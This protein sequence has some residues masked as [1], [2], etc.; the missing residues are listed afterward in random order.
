LGRILQVFGRIVRASGADSGACHRRVAALGHR[1]FNGGPRDSY[2]ARMP[3]N[4]AERQLARFATTRWSLIRAAAGPPADPEARGALAG[5]CEAY[6]Y[7]LYAFIRRRGYSS[8]DAQDLTQEFFARVLEKGFIKS[9]DADRGRFRSFLLTACRHFLANE[10]ERAGAKKRGAGRVASLELGSGEERYRREP[11]HELTPER[12]YERNW[13]LA[14][15]ER[16]LGRLRSEYDAAGKARLFDSLKPVLTG[17]DD[18]ASYRRLADALGMT[19]SALK[20]AAHRLRRRYRN[21]L[22][23]EV[24]DT[25]AGPEEVD[26]E[27]RHLFAA[28]RAGD[29]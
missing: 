14:L 8:T 26:D 9:A 18:G 25:V 3:D 7:P 16:V 21:L 2:N 28:L 10:R 6:W 15:L 22:C 17:H 19:Q 13:A 23:A 24:G 5:L 11:A 12:L 20:V 29:K 27:I 4:D 1:F